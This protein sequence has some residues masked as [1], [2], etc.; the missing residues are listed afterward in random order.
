M[1][2]GHTIAIA[3]DG[4]EGTSTAVLVQH[5]HESWEAAVLRFCVQQGVAQAEHVV[6]LLAAAGHVDEV[7]FPDANPSLVPYHDA[8]ASATAYTLPLLTP[9]GRPETHIVMLWE[10]TSEVRAEGTATHVHVRFV[11]LTSQRE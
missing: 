10:A 1:A 9:R 6:T 8:S 2:R 11:R 3:S 7:W 4:A 5:V